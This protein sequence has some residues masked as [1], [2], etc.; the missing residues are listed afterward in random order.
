[1]HNRFYLLGAFCVIENLTCFIIFPSCDVCENIL[2]GDVNEPYT[3]ML[4]GHISKFKKSAK[5]QQSVES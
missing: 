3:T 5:N 4:I 1:M 2:I